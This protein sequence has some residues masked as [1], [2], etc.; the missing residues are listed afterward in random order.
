ML[1]R[2]PFWKYLILLI[3][4]LVGLL[5]SL[6]NLYGEDVALQIT[7]INGN[8]PIKTT[9]NQIHTVLKKD[10]IVSK[11]I[12][13]ENGAILARFHNP[14]AQMRARE[15][16]IENLGTNF[17]VA[18]NLAPATPP[19]LARLGATPI[20]LGLDL[21]GG[22]HFLMEVDM[23]TILSKLQ[24]KTMDILSGELQE[25]SIPYDSI[26]KLS[27]NN[28]EVHFRDGTVIDKAIAYLGP[29]HQDLIFSKDGRNRLKVNVLSSHLREACKRAVQQ[30]ITILRNRINHLGVTEPIVQH[31][32]VDRIIVELPGIQDT[33][34][35]KEIL[36]ATTTLEFRLVNTTTDLSEAIKGHVP[37]DSELQYTRDGNPI[38]LYKRVILTGDHITDSTSSIEEY[39]QPQV[40]IS[41]D[42]VGG[43]LM[44]N[45]TKDNIGKPMS[46][47]S[48]EYKD[49]G[50]RG[51][52]G[53]GILVKQVEVIN[54]A[55]IQSHLGRKFRITGMGS[56]NEA[57]QLALLLRSG[58][59]IAPVR[60]SEERIIGPALG[61]KN[62]VQGLSACLLALLAS[63]IFMVICYRQFG[64]I[65]ATAL[66][67]N[68]LL[69]VSTMSIL[70]GVTLTMPG[71]AGIILTLAL[72][73]DA[74]VLIN[75]RIKEEL[76][77]KCSVQKAIHEGYKGALSS[78]ADA[79]ATTLITAIILYVMGTGAIKG[80]AITT[81]I[82]VVTS[83]FT[84]IIGTRA[85]VNLLYGG[86]R[87]S[88]LPI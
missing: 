29:R 36:G 78:I 26:R 38:V 71:I 77:N 48:V 7:N 15:A 44:S 54:V 70:P 75:E 52:N 47:L 86:K 87:A 58:A 17:I 20:K 5:C 43:I 1:N 2:Y 69:I 3:I 46:A 19:W 42:T 10:Y 4:I 64:V 25:K 65:A 6:P 8:V 61:Q 60:I 88:G 79:N 40:N 50:K 34:R 62:I 63:S 12:A 67:V 13:I 27:N 82:G 83:M 49:S 35:A 32:G 53:R 76:K 21:R 41:L 39:Q 23:D 57:R 28:L 16:L 74:T 56:A 9:L 59:F 31:Q 22:V 55:N 84:A 80:F 18:L 85:I 81:A 11:S 14:E 37:P 68:L 72:T 24:E 45:F 30:N 66:I 51:P 33:A 73:V